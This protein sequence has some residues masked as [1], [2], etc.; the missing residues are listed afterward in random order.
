MDQRLHHRF[1]LYRLLCQFMIGFLRPLTVPVEVLVRRNPGERYPG[2]AGVV[3]VLLMAAWAVLT[4][5]PTLALLDGTAVVAMVV[6]RVRSRARG[7][8]VVHTRFAGEPLLAVVAPGLPPGAVPWVEPAAVIAVGVVLATVLSAPLG[9][10]LACA[11]S[12]LLATTLVRA[13]AAYHR[14]LDQLDAEVERAAAEA[15]DASAPDLL[16]ATPARGFPLDDVPRLARV[17]DAV[18]QA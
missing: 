9:D 3:G 12:A 7:G 10:Y 16:F 5:S 1:P 8:P 18:V 4:A 14:R 2:F 13:A 17:F 11:G 6:A 15:R